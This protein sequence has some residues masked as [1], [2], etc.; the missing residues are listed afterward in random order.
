MMDI[1]EQWMNNYS[2]INCL[3]IPHENDTIS[4]SLSIFS[5]M[6]YMYVFLCSIY[7]LCLMVSSVEWWRWWWEV[8]LALPG[9][10]VPPSIDVTF[11]KPLACGRLPTLPHLPS[12]TLCLVLLCS[13]SMPG[14]MAWH[15]SFSLALLSPA[16]IPTPIIS[17]LPKHFPH[18]L[19]LSLPPPGLHTRLTFVHTHTDWLDGLVWEDRRRTDRKRHAAHTHILQPARTQFLP[20]ALSTHCLQH[21]FTHSPSTHLPL[22]HHHHH[23]RAAF[24]CK[25]TPTCPLRCT[26]C[27][28][29]CAAPL[30]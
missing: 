1:S 10:V 4:L 29:T 18:L 22:Y 28:P 26:T 20:P 14:G 12:Y 23:T 5:L 6:P 25:H 19:F 24:T 8:G 11:D 21:T 15:A 2:L 9:S 16:L 17:Q 30:F 13:S 27:P 3:L 7:L